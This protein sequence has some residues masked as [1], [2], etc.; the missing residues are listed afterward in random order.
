[1]P[2]RAGKALPTHGPTDHPDGPLRVGIM[3]GQEADITEADDAF[4]SIVGYSRLDFDAGRM[5]WR[6]MTPPEFLHLDEAGIR[7]A[8]QSGG[9]TVPYQKEFVRQDGTRVPVLL[10]CTFLP[11]TDGEWRGYVVDLSPRTFSPE[12]RQAEVGVADGFGPL[13]SELIRERSRM[14]TMLDNANALFWAIDTGYRLLSANASFHTAQREFSGRSIEIGDSVLDPA[15][16]SADTLDQWKGW[17]DRAMCGETFSV[18]LEYRREG[19]P[20]LYLEAALS[21]MYD[22]SGTVLGVSAVSFDVSAR[23]LAERGLLASEARFRTLAAASPMGIFLT[24][25][26]GS[27]MYSNPRLAAI[28]GLDPD[29][30]N[31][32]GL[33][34]A[35]HPADKSDA[36]R[37]LDH[38]LS[39]CVVQEADLR[40]VTPEGSVRHLHVKVAPV[41]DGHHEGG[42]CSGLVGSVDD[43]TEQRAMAQRVRQREKMESLGTLAGGIAH[44]FNNMLG[45]VLGHAELVL[46]DIDQG[47]PASVRMSIEEIRT[48]SLR[49]R[50]L[51]RQIL[52]FSRRTGPERVPAD[53]VAL[54]AESLRMMR[55]TLPASVRIES[56]LP[57]QPLMILGDASALQQII[58]NLCTNAEYAMRATGGGSLTVTLERAIHEGADSAVLTVR[59]SGSGMTTRVRDRLFE[60]FFTTKPVGEGT[61]MGLAVVHGVVRA[62]GGSISVAS[63]LG[64]G[65]SFHV[66]FPLLPV[67][68]TR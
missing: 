55:V 62:H 30:M 51:V 57:D 54:T 66:A 47:D 43:I 39:G 52:T 56:Q 16:F 27:C 9:Y 2:H 38:A 41:W 46:M 58:V 18:N 31:G 17:Y 1:M 60:P 21:P 53:L 19:G 13:I 42:G 3:R 8:A 23:T 68:A 67:D 7:Q 63:T 33:W 28:C 61:G 5:N 64:E 15:G 45:V 14:V 36:Q 12:A 65:T 20:D 22:G 49:A 44:D 32:S 4:L 34:G 59:D 29:A 37:M 25:T 40:V 26:D 50:D 6:E 10:V 11:G 24:D 35:V 48:A